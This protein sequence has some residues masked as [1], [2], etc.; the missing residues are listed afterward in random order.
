LKV[1][2]PMT[3][4]ASILAQ[5]LKTTPALGKAQEVWLDRVI[6]CPQQRLI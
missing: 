5:R 4:M 2:K 3:L 1:K 6:F